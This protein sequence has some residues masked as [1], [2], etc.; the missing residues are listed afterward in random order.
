MKGIARLAIA[1]V[2]TLAVLVPVALAQAEPFGIEGFEVTYTNEDG[3]QATQAGSHPFA[4]TT[5]FTVKNTVEAGKGFVPSGAVRDLQVT[6]PPG[7][8]G[9]TQATPRCATA[10]FTNFATT[11]EPPYQPSCSPASVVG[12][13]STLLAFVSTDEPEYRSSAVYNLV[14]PSGMVAMLGFVAEGGIAITIELRVN[15][16]APYNVIGTVNDVP[17]PVRFYGSVLTI[18]GNP[19]SPVHD[20]FRGGCLA[21]TV[22]T[23]EP[24]SI[25]TGLC[26]SGAVER[27]FLTLPVTCPGPQALLSR[28]SLVPWE[29]PTV[30]ASAQSPAP[31]AGMADCQ[32]LSFEPTAKATLTSQ[33]SGSSS[34]LDFNL[35]FR[36]EGLTSPTGIAQSDIRRAVVALPPGVALNPSAATG[37]DACSEQGFARESVSSAPGEGCPEASKIGQVSVETPLLEGT[38]LP[39]SVYVATPFQNPFGSLLAVYM[40]IKDPELGLMVKLPGK[41]TPDEKTGQLTTVF[42]EPP[43]EVPQ[44]PFSHFNFHFREGARA[45]LTTPST[46]G[47]FN[48][49]TDLEPWSAPQSGGNASPQA[50]LTVNSG[51]NGGSCVGSESALPNKPGF[52]AGTTIPVGGRYAPFVL[53]LTREAGT[54]RFAAIDATLPKGLLGKLAGVTECSDAQIAA[55]AAR[56]GANEGAL[57]RANPS[58]PSSS[59]VGTVTVGAGSGAPAYVQGKA[60]LAGPYKGAPLSLVIITPAISGP[61]DLGTVVVRSALYVNETTAQIHAVSDPIPTILH[62]IP[63]DVRSV[64][65]SMDRPEFTLNP[66]NCEP[67]QITGSETSTLGQ[68]AP[69][70]NP[71]DVSGCGKLNFG[72]QLKL[73]FKGQTKRGGNPGVKAVLTQPAGEAGIAGV[74]TVLPKTEFIDNAHISNPCTRVQFNANSCPAKSILGKATAWSP[75]LAKPLT[76]PVY[77]RSNGGERELPDIVAALHGQINVTLVGFIDS[78]KK[79]GEEVSRVRTRFLNVPDAPVSRF[80]LEL[81][82]GKKGLLENT[83]NLCKGQ[84]KATVRMDG[85]NGRIHDTSPVVKVT[86]KKSKAGKQNKAKH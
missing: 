32:R 79:K 77:F 7:V 5:K 37:L 19:A 41:V 40:V 64:A 69:L 76:G 63:L 38:V 43:Y 81:S 72:P 4:V 6:L 25:S 27:P 60:Y 22:A 75:L 80:V 1:A 82:G 58:C 54:Q 62:G 42:G 39:G 85:Q 78:V 15:P 44:F 52:E 30:E 68:T 9:D 84:R 33:Q 31:A 21:N 70:S 20:A 48:A 86:C 51:P 18:W 71:F 50:N 24:E 61:F 66:T 45:P 29:D 3:S 10:D 2:V 36:D 57:E 67:A 49:T 46:C 8:V 35:E 83:T 56:S 65:L 13:V 26:P 23:P 73:E 74:T 17:Q 53:N 14:P 59:K 28:I 34:G 55:A 47:G 12:T 16:E 11:T